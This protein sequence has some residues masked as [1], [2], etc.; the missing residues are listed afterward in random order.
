MQEYISAKIPESDKAEIVVYEDEGFFCKKYEERPQFQQMLRDIKLNKQNM[1][2]CY[3]LDRIS[4]NVSDFSSL[5]ETRTAIIFHLSVSRK[6][7]TPQS[8]WERP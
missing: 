2:F 3:R 4:R 5:I 6:N 7:S 1:L 8:L